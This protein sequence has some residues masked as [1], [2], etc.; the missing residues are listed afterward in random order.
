M[1]PVLEHLRLLERHLRGQPTLAETAAWQLRLH[2]EPKL[3]AET[4]ELRQLYA[5]LR[6]AGRQQ[7]RQELAAIHARLYPPRRRSWL[8]A[9]VAAAVWQ[10][11]RRR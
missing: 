4:A 3:A 9:A 8:R 2:Q 6:E 7:L 10:L 1:R 11:G 5:G